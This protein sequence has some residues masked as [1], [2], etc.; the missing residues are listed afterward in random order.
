MFQIKD[1]AN[2]KIQIKYENEH[3][4]EWVEDMM[5][6][7]ESRRTY[8]RVTHAMLRILPLHL[9]HPYNLLSLD[10]YL[11]PHSISNRL[12]LTNR[13]LKLANANYFQVSCRGKYISSKERLTHI[14]TSTHALTH[15]ISYSF[16]R[17]LK[18]WITKLDFFVLGI[19]DWAWNCLWNKEK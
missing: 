1:F 5:V 7:C 2:V 6:E 12:S 19:F 9:S 8:T 17:F 4:Q 11:L 13:T 10:C 3:L 15:K 16:G 14:H 18:H